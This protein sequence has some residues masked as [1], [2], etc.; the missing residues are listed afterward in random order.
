MLVLDT[1]HVSL[2]QWG[3]GDEAERL[4]LRLQNAGDEMATTIITYEEQSRGWLAFVAGAR[5]MAAQVEAYRRLRRHLDLYR[6]TRVLD[7]DA[8]A[9]TESQRLRRLR[10]RVGT[11]DL[12]IAAIALVHSARLLTRN[13]VDFSKVPGLQFEDWTR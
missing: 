10:I 1:D 8:A 11:M 4:R 2:L 7:F 3:T 5:T 12:R 9:A 13:T 6:N